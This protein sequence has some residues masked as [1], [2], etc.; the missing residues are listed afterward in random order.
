MA[1]EQKDNFQVVLNK[2]TKPNKPTESKPKTNVLESKWIIWAHDTQD[3]NWDI[4]SYKKIYEFDTIEDFWIFFN[5]IKHFRDFM[6]FI[7]RGDILPIYE[8]PKCKNGGY[9]SYVVQTP[10]LSNSIILLLTRMIG[11][12]LTDLETFD[13]VI[14]MSVSPKGNRSVIKIWNKNKQERLNF[15]LKDRYFKGNCRYIPHKK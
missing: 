4:E 9:Y 2:Q 1:Q 5:N 10:Q 11:E 6:L 8:D 14:G 12:T 15:Y 7:M 3:S 13:E